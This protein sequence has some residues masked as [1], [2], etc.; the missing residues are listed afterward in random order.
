MRLNMNIMVS[1]SVFLA[2][3]IGMGCGKKALPGPPLKEEIKKV[4]DLDYKL[5]KDRLTLRW[6]IPVDSKGHAQVRGFFVYRA[7]DAASMKKCEKCPLVFEKTAKKVI[8]NQVSGKRKMIY[9]EIL[10]PGYSYTYKV[11]GYKKGRWTGLDSN[12]IELIY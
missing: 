6:S 1:L 9:R 5:E 2:V 8:K 3:F 11:V 12:Y 4:E 10:E 7:M